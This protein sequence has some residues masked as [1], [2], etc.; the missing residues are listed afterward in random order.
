M[1]KKEYLFKVLV[2][3]ECETGKT[4]IITQY[5]HRKFENNYKATVT[6]TYFGAAF[7]KYLPTCG[8]WLRHCAYAHAPGTL[9]GACAGDTKLPTCRELKYVPKYVGLAG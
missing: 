5:V 9:C 2:V 7:L 6:M 4:S 8:P 3:G 1:E